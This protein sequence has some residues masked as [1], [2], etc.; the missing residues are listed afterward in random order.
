MPR[1]VEY[2]LGALAGTHMTMAGTDYTASLDQYVIDHVLGWY[3]RGLLLVLRASVRKGDESFPSV[4]PLVPCAD[5][6]ER[7]VKE[8]LGLTPVGHPNPRK[9]LLSDDWPDDLFPMRKDFKSEAPPPLRRDAG[10][11]FT[12]PEDAA[13]FNI[14]PYGPYHF[15][16]HEPIFFRFHVD[17]ERIAGVDLRA[18]FNHRGLEKIAETRMTYETVPFIAERVCGICGSVHAEAYT[19]ALERA[20]GFEP[21][22]RAKWIRVAVLEMERIHSHLLWLGVASHMVGFDTGLMQFWRVRDRIMFLAELLTGN[23]KQYGMIVPG[24]V[25]RDIRED[26]RETALREVSTILEEYEELLDAALRLGTL[27]ARLEGVGPLTEAEARRHSVMGPLARASGVSMDARRDYPYEAYG[28]LEF[29]TPVREEGDVLARTIV[30][31][32]DTFES[33]KLVKQALEGLPGG[34]VHAPIEYIPPDVASVGLVEGPRGTDVHYLITGGEDT[35]YR[36]RVRAPTYANLPVA[37]IMLKG[38]TLADA[39]VI[40]GS[41]DPCISCAER[42]IVVDEASGKQRLVSG[43]ELRGWRA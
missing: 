43:E 42:V 35:V 15:A 2:A 20:A 23:R 1:V 29:E 5:W 10:F 8:S 18:G 28:Q 9:L 27:K 11:T 17:G 32:Y 4:T 24:G 14:V 6:Y 33:I 36:W 34:P 22:E 7:E 12:A 41:I 40:I 30:R 38:Q 19:Q 25:R 26:K 39:S 13:M 21:P 16:I 37:P 3:D 31:A